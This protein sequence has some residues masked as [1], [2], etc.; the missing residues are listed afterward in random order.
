MS[1]LIAIEA[2]KRDLERTCLNGTI[3]RVEVRDEKLLRGT[4]PHALQDAL[5]R[6]RFTQVLRKGKFLL[7]QTDRG[8][9]LIVSMY[10]DA[11]LAC[12]PSPATDH[13]TDARLI[14]HFD[15]G[16]S[17]DLRVPSMND[18]LYFFPTTDER[19]MEPLQGLGPDPRE[20][21]YMDF[22]KALSEKIEPSTPLW[23]AL[24]S[25]HRIAGLDPALA[26]EICFQGRVRPDRPVSTLLRAD[27]ERLY[28]KM[29]KILKAVAELN[30]DMQELDR[31]GYLM[32]RRGNDRGCPSGEG[33]SVLH[34]DGQKSYFCPS[35]QEDAPWEGKKADFW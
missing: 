27:W 14:V 3:M 35:C 4:D 20:M 28:D 24:L 7:L 25:Q 10:A 34:L 8:Q 1:D 31:R 5:A 12:V 26:D 17:M 9:T 11:D 6:A 2:R 18:L 16:H 22:R 29:Q 33:I 23:I 32:P 15:D 19:A 13:P 21:T 30:G